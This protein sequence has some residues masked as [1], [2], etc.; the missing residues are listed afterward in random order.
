MSLWRSY[1]SSSFTYGMTKSVC[2]SIIRPRSR[3]STF[4]P[5]FASSID[6]IEP[7]TPLPTTTASTGVILIV[8]TLFPPNLFQHDVLREAL[9]IGLGLPRLDVENAHRLGVIQVGIV[10]VRVVGAGR[11]TGKS[12]KLPP[13][14]ASV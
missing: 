10:E 12:Q 1:L 6:M 13:H 7:T 11:D 4:K 14:L 3:Q 9:R 2:G 5:A 8:A